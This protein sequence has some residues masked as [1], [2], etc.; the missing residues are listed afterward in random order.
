MEAGG[1]DVQ[2]V[3]VGE[4]KHQQGS[5]GVNQE[6]QEDRDDLSFKE[7]QE[8][9][10][11]TQEEAQLLDLQ[12]AETTKFAFSLVSVKT[13]DDEEKPQLPQLRYRDSVGEPEPHLEE[14]GRMTDSSE[15]DISDGEWEETSKAQSCLNPINKIPT[16]ETRD[17]EEEKPFSCSECGRRFSH[18]GNL[19][20]HLRTH[21]GEKPFSCSECS[22]TFSRNTNLK[23]HLRI[24]SG[25]KR[26]SCSV[27]HKRFTWNH[28]LKTHR[29]VSKSAHCD[30]S[31]PAGNSPDPTGNEDE[32]PLSCSECGRRFRHGSDLSRHLRSHTG[33]KPFSCSECG[34][35]FNDK[36]T[37]TNH[38]RTHTGEKPFGCSICGRNFTHSVSLTQ[39]LKT[40]TGEKPFGCSECGKTFSRST[41]LKAH[42]RIHNGEKRFS[43]RFCDR[44]F[45][46]KHHM[47]DHE[48]ICA[49]ASRGRSKPDRKRTLMPRPNSHGLVV[50]VKGVSLV[51]AVVETQQPT[52]CLPHPPHTEV[53]SN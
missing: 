3:I 35:G 20:Q 30:R 10:W 23:A 9:L 5:S 52:S 32:K 44:R 40:H 14:D 47:I 25:E 31:R 15:T 22:K 46:R 38:L 1:E 43:C 16:A 34:R 29:C 41:N 13:E 26:F 53:T 18:S 4:E 50:L 11:S 2:K 49:S 8:Q 37:L 24:H 17:D 42:L 45:T 48:R 51:S 6:K 12:E 39:H 36:S 19:K 28:H 27:C 33:E 7:E 21:T